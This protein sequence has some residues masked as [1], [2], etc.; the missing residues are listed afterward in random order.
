MTASL[1]AIG[2]LTLAELDRY[3]KQC[4]FVRTSLGKTLNDEQK[5]HIATC[6]KMG[7]RA[8]LDLLRLLGTK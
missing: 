3:H 4:L 1:R 6:V 2:T 5:I 7:R 8:E